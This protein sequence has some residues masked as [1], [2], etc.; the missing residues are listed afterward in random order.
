MGQPQKGIAMLNREVELY[1]ESQPLITMVLKQ[2][3]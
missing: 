1:P 3:Q 2:V